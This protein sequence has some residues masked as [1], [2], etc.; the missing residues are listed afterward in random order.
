MSTALA[1]RVED[2]LSAIGPRERL[3]LDLREREGAGYRPIADRLGT[4]REGVADLLVAARLGV[5][6][7]L[8]DEPAP[9][10]R[11]SHCAPARRVLVA[12][13][14]GETVTVAD[15]DRAREHLLECQPCQAARL[16]LREAE[17]A[18]RAWR[19]TPP[20][21]AAEPVSRSGG[22]IHRQATRFPLPGARRRIVAVAVLVVVLV[23]IVIAAVTSGGDAPVRP[24]APAPGPG[25]AQGTGKDVVPPPGD[26]FC[27]AEQP[28]CK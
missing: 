22:Y 25:S 7:H 9:P 18:C 24:A 8:H 3:A 17:L 20:T 5:W 10:R 27:P 21:S 11:T 2:A 28:D 14:D 26:R 12:Q 15:A 23:A 16:A 4:G 1:S 6:S 13:D 19:A